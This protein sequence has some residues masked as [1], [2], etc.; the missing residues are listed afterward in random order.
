METFQGL[1]DW[2]H[3]SK[4]PRCS[5]DFWFGPNP[6]DNNFGFDPCQLHVP[7]Y[8]LHT[9]LSV[10]G[11][12]PLPFMPDAGPDVDD[13]IEEQNHPKVATPSVPM[14]AMPIC[15]QVAKTMGG[16]PHSL[17]R[18]L[19]PGNMLGRNVRGMP[20]A[21]TLDRVPV[22]LNA[23]DHKPSISSLV[24]RVRFNTQPKTTTSSWLKGANVVYF[25][26][27]RHLWV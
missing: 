26:G 20:A 4:S 24:S 10:A 23:I 5:S 16:K 21:V 15:V 14:L 12:E 17:G 8:K 2:F 7:P 19:P 3:N 27:W 18:R 11:V 9:E 6:F 1:T 25:G 13:L 22:P